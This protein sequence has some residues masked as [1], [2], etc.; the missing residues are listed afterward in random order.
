MSGQEENPRSRRRSFTGFLG[1]T[2]LNLGI[3]RERYKTVKK[4]H[5][6]EARSV[7]AAELDDSIRG[8]TSFTIK[9]HSNVVVDPNWNSVGLRRQ[10]GE[11]EEEEEGG[12][13]GEER[14]GGEE[15][16]TG[17]AAEGEHEEGVGN[18]IVSSS[19]KP[20]M[21]LEEEDAWLHSFW[22]TAQLPVFPPSGAASIKQTVLPELPTAE[23]L[24]N[25]F[26]QQAEAQRVVVNSV[27]ERVL[28]EERRRVEARLFEQ[29]EMHLAAFTKK[30]AAL[31]WREQLA[32]Q[33]VKEQEV[34][35]RARLTAERQRR[36]AE[37]LQREA[38]LGRSFR[39]AREALEGAVRRQGAALVEAFGAMREGGASLS[40]RLALRS[41]SL[42]QPLEIRVHCLRAVK[43]KL[44]RGAYVVMASMFKSLG[45]QPLAWT[46]LATNGI[47]P[48]FGGTTRAAKH[49]G[50]FFDKALRFEDSVFCLCPPVGAL[51]PSYTLVLELFRLH[52]RTNALDRCEAWTAMPLCSEHFSVPQ[53]R[54]KLP[55]LRGCHSPLVQSYRDM[56]E[57]VARDLGAWLCNGYV[58][59]RLFPLQEAIASIQEMRGALGNRAAARIV[60]ESGR[61][62]LDF[63]NKTLKGAVLRSEGGEAKEEELEGEP[64][65]WS[66]QAPLLSRKPGTGDRPPPI[67]HSKHKGH[68]VLRSLP[69]LSL[70]ESLSAKGIVSRASS[71]AVQFGSFFV[72]A[73]AK[74]NKGR[75][76]NRVYAAPNDDEGGAEE[77]HEEEGVHEFSGRDLSGSVK[78][79]VG[80]R[81]RSHSRSPSPPGRKG[82]SPGDGECEDGSGEEDEGE[83]EVDE[84]SSDVFLERGYGPADEP[85]LH[86]EQ[87]GKLGGIEAVDS[88][89]GRRWAASGLEGRMVRRLQSDG[90][91]L[92]SEALEGSDGPQ[93]ASSTAKVCGVG[94]LP[95]DNARDMDRYSCSIASNASQ[96]RRLLPGAVSAFKLRLLLHEA[97]G[98]LLP[99]MW[100]S[101]DFVVT[102]LVLLVAL[103]VRAWLH[104]LAQYLY[105]AAYGAPVFA[106][107]LQ[108]LQISF[109]YMSS[110][111]PQ[112]VEVG[113]V[114]IGPL[115]LNVFFLGVCLAGGLFHALAG[116]I[117]DACSKFVACFGLA[118]VLD[119]LLVLVVDLGYRN[120]DC[121]QRPGCGGIGGYVSPDCACFVGDFI[122]LWARTQRDEGSGITGLLVTLIL[123]AGTAAVSTL[124]LAEYFVRVHRNARV[125]DLSRRLCAPA[126]EFFLPADFEVSHDEL[127][128]VCLRSESWRGPGGARRRVVVHEYSETD[129]LD[130]TF[131]GVLSH[132][133]IYEVS[134]EGVPVKLFRQFVRGSDG[135]IV[136]TF[137]PLVFA[138]ETASK[139]TGAGQG[140]D[141]AERDQKAHEAA[142]ALFKT[143]RRLF[144]GVDRA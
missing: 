44:P 110:S 89:E 10:E 60:T 130:P 142:H 9:R 91:R 46:R 105:L 109:K 76:D 26:M 140:P 30:E 68:R 24:D 13:E 36:E 4:E 115:A 95:L 58:E 80:D 16:G 99:A 66:E 3:L 61:L 86:A 32:G 77:E 23:S 133:A 41:E 97:L 7:L 50:R 144:S 73:S 12:E 138:S 92:D 34:Q 100:G 75:R 98:D 119:P 143:R 56:E 136:E 123:Y 107:Q 84:E 55:F 64:G 120:Y 137:G 2:Q 20:E 74:G 48:G 5:E 114:A 38:G 21:A 11:R 17:K 112:A 18:D 29:R 49:Q 69:S 63:L 72:A 82:E 15:F 116:F 25:S 62:S 54:F 108:A 134:A 139:P 6:M 85:F 96:R 83:E 47:G 59:L 81:V 57:A 102:V 65:P 53:G 93:G 35:A 126:V 103:W 135:A 132:V 118:S 19:G 37:M 88:R 111:L 104:Y 28:R 70:S 39:R 27:P 71:W 79:I 52:A 122:K 45:G 113:L 43:E 40:R 141:A 125:L 94:W 78:S 127:C 33:R 121:E 8:G 31:V 90:L 14:V 51:Q 22:E 1:R 42:P 101:L 124:V 131:H 117:P 129:R 106:F 67:S 87:R 128:H